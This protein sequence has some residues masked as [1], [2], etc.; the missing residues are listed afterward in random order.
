MSY[1]KTLETLNINIY[2]AQLENIHNHYSFGK[3]SFFYEVERVLTDVFSSPSGGNIP[4]RMYTEHQKKLITS[5]EWHSLK[6][7][8]SKWFIFGHRLGKFTLNK[9]I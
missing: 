2:E 6:S 9:H 1:W 3:S 4:W 7:T 8:E 5:S